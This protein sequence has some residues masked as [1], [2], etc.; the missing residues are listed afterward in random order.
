[1]DIIGH[2]KRDHLQD[3]EEEGWNDVDMYSGERISSR[4]RMYS[5]YLDTTLLERRR[6]SSRT[7][8]M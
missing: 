6:S 7:T 3:L 4:N 2:M 5:L 8:W 1:M